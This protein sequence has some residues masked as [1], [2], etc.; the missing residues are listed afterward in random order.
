MGYG[1]KPFKTN[2]TF[3][4][5]DEPHFTLVTNRLTKSL[6][7]KVTTLLR[8]ICAATVKQRPS[9]RARPPRHDDDAAMAAP[10]GDLVRPMAAKA[11]ASSRVAA[12]PLRTSGWLGKVGKMGKMGWAEHQKTLGRLK[13]TDFNSLKNE[14]LFEYEE[15]MAWKIG[16]QKA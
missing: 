13:L 2:E 3:S 7:A 4:K 16:S 14:D 12:G 10:R 1:S 8:P 6:N 15:W 5:I 11:E 9:S